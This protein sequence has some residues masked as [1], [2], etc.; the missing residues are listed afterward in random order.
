MKKSSDPR[1]LKRIKIIQSL[2]ASSFQAKTYSEN[3]VKQIKKYGPK[4]DS[5]I[6]IA[7]PQFP[8][9]KISKIDV[10]ILRLAVY[11][12]TI[13]KKQPPKVVIDE[14]IELAKE[15]GGEASSAFV[16]GVLGTILKNTDQNPK[17]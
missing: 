9:N 3:T 17:F 4:I 11:E 12:L 7:A 13:E 1:H 10:A 14:A 5:L 8:I 16:N 2:F 15:F 6:S